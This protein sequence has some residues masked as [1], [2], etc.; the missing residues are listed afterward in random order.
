MPELSTYGSSWGNARP[1]RAQVAADERWLRNVPQ[2]AGTGSGGGGSMDEQRIDR[3]E[4]RMDK[5]TDD[6]SLIRYDIGRIQGALETALPNIAT[7]ADLNAKALQ[8]V[9]WSIGTVITVSGLT[10]GIIK[11]TG[12]G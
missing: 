4:T 3:L 11:F 2:T 1:G 9:L 5:M 12:S 8:L 7:K 6:V 10:F